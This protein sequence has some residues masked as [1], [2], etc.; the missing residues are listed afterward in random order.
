MGKHSDTLPY[1]QLEVLL[2]VNSTPYT[3]SHMMLIVLKD[4]LCWKLPIP[5]HRQHHQNLH[6]TLLPPPLRDS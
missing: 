5:N 2:N 4:N 1:I 6:P 3:I